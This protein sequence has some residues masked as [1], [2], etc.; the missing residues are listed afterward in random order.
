L[1]TKKK[2]RENFP[3]EKGG[4]E[5]EGRSRGKVLHRLERWNVLGGGFYAPVN[6][7][8]KGEKTELQLKYDVWTRKKIAGL[9]K[10]LRRLKKRR[11]K[12]LR[13][14]KNRLLAGTGAIAKEGPT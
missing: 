5:G 2:T 11:D 13:R 1:G 9:F 3:V 7:G 14:S 12:L 10:K 6:R 4:K 8:E